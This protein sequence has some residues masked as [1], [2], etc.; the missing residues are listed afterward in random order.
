MKIQ[1]ELIGKTF[2]IITLAVALYAVAALVIGW[3][4]IRLEFLRFS[5]GNLLAL[6]GLSLGN[7]FLRFWRWE[8]YLRRLSSPLPFRQSLGL[9]FSSYVMVITPGKIGEAFKAG[10][11][12]EKFGVPL[13]KGLPIVLAERIYDFLAVLLLAIAGIFFWP[14]S[15]AGMT[16]GLEAA[17]ALPVLLLVFHHRKTRTR[18]LNKLARAPFLRDHSLALD[19]S[20]TALGTLLKPGQM[21]LSLLITVVAWLGECLGL[22]L[23]CRGLGAHI[24]VPEAVFVYAAGTL[25]GSLSF[26]PGGLGGTEATIIFLLQNLDLSSTSAATVAL[27]VRIFTLWFAVV[28]GLVFFLFFRRDLLGGSDG[29]APAAGTDPGS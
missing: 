24:P 15:F 25:V 4:S 20:M 10:I 26:L 14:G 28:I 16:T 23:A 19:E 27:L 18:L 7:Y 8:I 12:R 2:L 17:A 1:R 22:W 5:F 11:L 29:P 9:Y 3:N 13:A 21:A 6:A